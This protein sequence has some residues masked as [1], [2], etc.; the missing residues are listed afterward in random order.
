M[1]AKRYYTTSA[2]SEMLEVPSSTLRYWEEVFPM[3]NPIRTPGEG[4]KRHR[5]YTQTDI[6]TAAHIKQLLYVKGLKIEA[7]IEVM[8][9]THR[10]SRPHPPRP[11]TT[12]ERAVTLLNE[13]S[14]L[15][16]NSHALAKIKAVTQWLTQSKDNG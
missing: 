13:A 4:S 12:A 1:S 9:K 14:E 11:C 2:V 7:A 15:I 10:I 3:L 16:E 8:N 6:K 5:R